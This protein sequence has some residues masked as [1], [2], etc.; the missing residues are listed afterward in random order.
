MVI[1]VASISTGATVAT[2]W[3]VRRVLHRRRA[4]D[5][6]APPEHHN[7]TW[8][9]LETEAEVREAL[10]RALACEQASMRVSAHRA[11][12]LADL[13]RRL[14]PVAP[15]PQPAPPLPRDADIP[16]AS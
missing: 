10:E 8:R 5:P 3:S 16:R 14:T 4:G 15:A 1:E 13:R 7:P 11:E 9:L 12:R 2:G 6:V